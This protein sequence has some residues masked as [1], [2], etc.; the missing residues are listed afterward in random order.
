MNYAEN[1]SLERIR[2]KVETKYSGRYE[3]NRD[4][5]RLGLIYDSVQ[6]LLSALTTL[7]RFSVE[8]PE[9]LQVV[10]GEYIENGEVIHDVSF[11]KNITDTNN[12]GVLD[13]QNYSVHN[14]YAG[15]EIDGV[16]LN[17]NFDNLKRQ[18]PDH[19]FH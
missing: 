10:Y 19:T 1:S 6:H 13:Y 2:E 16:D 7:L 9:G 3:R 14:M 17:R 8:G 5:C 18:L 4:Y 12:N 11:R 15:G